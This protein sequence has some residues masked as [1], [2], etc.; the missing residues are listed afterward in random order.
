MDRK[1]VIDD[2]KDDPLFV[3]LFKIAVFCLAI[4]ALCLIAYISIAVIRV[5]VYYLDISSLYLMRI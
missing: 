5:T 3:K 4:L 2:K 1:E